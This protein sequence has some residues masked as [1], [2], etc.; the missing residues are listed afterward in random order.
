MAQYFTI[1]ELCA[2]DT[3]KKKGIDNRPSPNMVNELQKTIDFLNP[4]R[5]AWG[6]PIKV[7]S[8]YRSEALNKAVSGVSNSS[9]KYGWAVDLQPAKGTVREFWSFLKGYLKGS[10]TPFGQCLIEKSGMTQ[11][12]HLSRKDTSGQRCQFKE[13]NL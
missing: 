3:A 1:E 9:H 4:I 12:V 11:W 5:E 6:S 10:K 8:G 13:I 7:T 2:S